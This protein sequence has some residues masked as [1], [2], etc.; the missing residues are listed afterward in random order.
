MALSLATTL[1]N[2]KLAKSALKANATGMFLTLLLTASAGLFLQVDPSIP[3]IANRAELRYSDI[4]LA[5]A[6]GGAGA[7]SFTSGVSAAL[8]G[9]MVAVAIL[10]P[11]ATG[12]LLI[13]SGDILMGTKALLLTLANIICINLS[14]AG[15]FLYQKARPRYFWEAKR[16]RR[17]LRIAGVIW[18]ALLLF[19]VGVI[20][21]NQR[22]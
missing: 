12:G 22:F 15:M 16:A 11:V 21:L 3:A 4:L 9:V 19:L 5:L 6:A 10:P 20:Y 7:L 17:M 1:G 8:V 2:V 18:I 13:G 14:G